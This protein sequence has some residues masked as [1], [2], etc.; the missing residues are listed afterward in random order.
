M[1]TTCH[2]GT[3]PR[4][5]FRLMLTRRFGCLYPRR[6]EASE[7]RHQPQPAGRYR[8]DP[9]PAQ[10][11]VPSLPAA[12]ACCARGGVKRLSAYGHRICG[13]YVSPANRG[14][15][16]SREERTRTADLEPHYEGAV[17]GCWLLGLKLADPR[18]QTS[19]ASN[20]R[21]VGPSSSPRRVSRPAPRW[22]RRGRGRT[23]PGADRCGRPRPDQAR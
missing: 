12:A 1:G 8:S 19:K 4:R 2:V 21:R 13:R 6:R 22:V 18:C 5:L 10:N 14:K 20:A 23:C 11:F 15:I 9:A 7:D 17:S 3:P 16:K